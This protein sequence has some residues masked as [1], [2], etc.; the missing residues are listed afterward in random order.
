MKTINLFVD[1]EFTSLSPDA[2]IISLGIVS[3]ETLSIGDKFPI[4]VLP[5]ELISDRF[6]HFVPEYIEY[7]GDVGGLY[8]LRFDVPE[9]YRHFY[10]YC[11]HAEFFYPTHLVNLPIE[12]P[13]SFYAEFT[14]FDINRC[15]D[16]VKENVVGKLKYNTYDKFLPEYGV[17]DMSGK[18][19]TSL[20]KLWLYRYL[21]QFSGYQIQIVVDCGTFDWY[22]FL[23]LVAEWDEVR[24]NETYDRESDGKVCD[25]YRMCG[26]PKLPS[27]ISPV[28]LDLNDLIAFKNGI[29]V[30]E[31]FELYREKLADELNGFEWWKASEKV[32][33]D[34]CKHNALWDAKVIKAIYE[35]IK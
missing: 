10:M 34:I 24:T 16:W 30:K 1:F 31:A 3:D 2:Q 23:Q 20:I 9:E 17:A 4:S 29:S 5:E 8:K 26:L 12:P 13:K 35:K 33:N 25:R 18:G 7:A 21:E 32:I 6:V 14:C 11:E 19:S 27:N 22:H 15:D 28:P